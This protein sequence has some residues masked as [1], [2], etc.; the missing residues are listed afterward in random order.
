ME[1][2]NLNKIIL[3][4]KSSSNKDLIDSMNFLSDD[5]EQ[6]KQMIINLSLHLDN[7]ENLYNKIYSEYTIRNGR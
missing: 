6:T 4:I 1:V 3:D 7:I 2:E 5:F